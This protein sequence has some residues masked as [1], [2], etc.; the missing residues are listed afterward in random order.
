[1]LEFILLGFLMEFDQNGYQMK[2]HMAI[3]TSNFMDA[4][5]GSLYPA[6]KRLL[7]K[8]LIEVKESVEK[9]KCTKV[10]SINKQGR[11]V[12]LKW[13]SEPAKIAPSAHDHLQKLYFYDFL[14]E[15]TKKNHYRYYIE[16]AERE[17]QVLIAIIPEALKVAGHDRRQTME[18]GIRYYE[19]IIDFYNSLLKGGS[20]ISKHLK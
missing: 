15:D 2:R 1:M 20:D 10:Y 5:Y 18:Y 4:S 13:L 17:K 6:L 7:E 14:D 12:F 19:N 11:S 9:G 16:S 8:G 3:G